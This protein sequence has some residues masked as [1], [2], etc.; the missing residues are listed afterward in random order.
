MDRNKDYMPA[1]RK[2]A[3]DRKLVWYVKSYDTLE[4]RSI[5]EHV[6]N[7][8]DWQDFKDMLQIMG[9]GNAARVFRQWAFAK[10]S[11]YHKRTAEYFNLYFN[12]YAPTS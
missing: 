11:N 4:E 6:L 8:G 10:R 7:Y 9:V 1:L 3:K 2:L 5:V 12:K